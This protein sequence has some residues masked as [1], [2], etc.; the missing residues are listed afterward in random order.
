MAAA[1]RHAIDHTRVQNPAS[2]VLFEIICRQKIGRYGRPAVHTIRS[3][4][5]DERVERPCLNS[6][7]PQAGYRGGVY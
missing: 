3:W 1:L 6:M 2:T 4:P 7:N 5:N